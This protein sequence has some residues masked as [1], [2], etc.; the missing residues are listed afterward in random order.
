MYSDLK[1]SKEELSVNRVLADCSGEM[2]L[3]RDIV[4]PDYYP[5]IFRIL[6]CTV[7]PSVV[8]QSIN[9]SKLSID[10]Q[11]LIRILYLSEND[12]RINCIEQKVPLSKSVEIQGECVDPS[13]KVGL[14]CDHINCRVVNRRRLDIRGAVTAKIKVCCEAPVQIITGAAGAGIQLKKQQFTYPCKRLTA[15][16]RITVIEE[17]ELPQSKPSIGAVLRCGCF[18]TGAEQKVIAGK[19]V[20]KGEAEISLLYSCVDRSGEDAAESLR[21]TLPFSQI[22]DVDG[23][24]ESFDADIDITAADCTVLPKGEN[25]NMLECELVLNVCCSAVKYKSGEAVTDAYSIDYETALEKCTERIEMQPI[26][27]SGACR[28]ECSLT[29]GEGS[30]GSVCD[31]FA[32]CSN[33]SVRREGAKLLITGSVDHTAIGISEEK[34]PFLLEGQTAFEH[35][36]DLPEGITDE[37]EL[38]FEP[39]AEVTGCSYFLNDSNGL[40]IKADIRISGQLRTCISCGVLSNISIDGEKPKTK[41]CTY[42]LK[43]CRCDGEDIWDI[44]K[45]YSTSVKAI[46]EEN[47]DAQGLLLIPIGR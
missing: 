38:F 6:K 8:S 16:K 15:A 37:N 43:L 18:I 22:I 9:G 44:A 20:A 19:L 14:C 30:I 10:A 31:C 40:D 23:I 32:S 7:T 42:A 3:E 28:S 33:I 5:D 4:L 17:T 34:T 47:P 27:I 11:A 36:L 24:D 25:S 45:K 21:F 29:Y 39:K 1:L 46:T 13:V 2:S 41:D 12:H 26:P 35:E